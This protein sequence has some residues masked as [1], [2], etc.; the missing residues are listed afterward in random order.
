MRVWDQVSL[1]LLGIVAVLTP[2]EVAFMQLHVDF[3]F[4]FNRAI[5]LAFTFDM[6][7][8]F[9]LAYRNTEDGVWV[10]SHA[11]IAARYLRGWFLIDLLSVLPFDV[12]G[13]TMNNAS[14]SQLRMLRFIRLAR[15]VKLMRVLR[16]GRIFKRWESTMNVHYS[17]LALAKFIGWMLMLSHWLACMWELT[18][19]VEAMTEFHDDGSVIVTWREASGIAELPPS[20]RY[21][22]CVYWAAMTLS[23]IGYGDITPVTTE[24][25]LVVTLAMLLGACLWAYIVA[26]VCAIVTAL[27]QHGLELKA[28]R[29]LAHLCMRYAC[30]VCAGSHGAHVMFQQID[31]LN[32]FMEDKQ[33]GPQWRP[34][35]RQFFL[36]RK[37]LT[38]TLSHRKLLVHMSPALRGEVCLA[39]NEAWIGKV[40]YFKDIGE[41]FSTAVALQLQP[42]VFAPEE[43][44]T[45]MEL[46][47]VER[48]V[49]LKDGKVFASG[50]VWGEDM[51]LSNPRLRMTSPA[52][53]LTYVDVQSL[54]KVSVAAPWVVAPGKRFSVLTNCG[55]WQHALT[56]IM[57]RFP[58]RAKK[59]RRAALWIA[60]RRLLIIWAFEHRIK[61]CTKKGGTLQ[62]ANGTVAAEDAKL[63]C[64]HGHA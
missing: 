7:L 50:M 8:N 28:V 3:L 14:V 13:V 53:T 34:R 37:R 15:L 11:K 31:A 36:N 27:D 41:H 39:M 62:G 30:F 26:N 21:L 4:F 38:M 33:L 9:F 43:L 56:M 61:A 16:V 58:A 5:D 60:M 57:K 2:Y 19:L 47:I 44:I 24:E 1:L 49:C 23:T 25:R 32:Y 48:G 22:K 64:A 45:G 18:S 40:A 42:Q 12:F 6:V 17:V 46:H 55:P 35:L 20:E 51:I 54:S 63:V 52:T 29:W 59:V 10:R